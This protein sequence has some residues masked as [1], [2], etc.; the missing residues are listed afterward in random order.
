MEEVKFTDKH[1]CPYCGSSNVNYL[2]LTYAASA[3]PESEEP[4]RNKYIFKCE[5]CKKTFYFTGKI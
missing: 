5:D 3:T 2:D 1:E 4:K